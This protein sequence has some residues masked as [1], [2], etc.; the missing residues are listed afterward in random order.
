M[1]WGILA[2]APV[3][4]CASERERST[5]LWRPKM[6]RNLRTV[7]CLLVL[8][9]VSPRLV[10]QDESAASQPTQTSKPKDEQQKPE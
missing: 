7:A 10:A 2:S 6:K 1:R 4:L 3:P 5:Y 8:G 9:S